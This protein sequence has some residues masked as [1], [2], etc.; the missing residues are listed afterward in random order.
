MI[1]VIALLLAEPRRAAGTKC[2]QGDEQNMDWNM[3]ILN[4]QV[5]HW[6][7]HAMN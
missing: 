2:K 6:G 3:G 1:I 7:C 5:E 4:T